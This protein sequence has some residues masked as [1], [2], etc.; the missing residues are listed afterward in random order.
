MTSSL[1]ELGGFSVEVCIT[2]TYITASR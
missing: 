1:S 2:R